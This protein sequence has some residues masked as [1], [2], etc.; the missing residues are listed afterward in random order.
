M[1][2]ESG[3]PRRIKVALQEICRQYRRGSGLREPIKTNIETIIS[4]LLIRV[5]QDMKVV[6][7]CLNAIAQFGRKDY[8]LNGVLQSIETHRDNPEIAGSAV[9]ALFKIDSKTLKDANRITVLPREIIALGALQNTHPSRLDLTGVRIN[10]ERAAPD[11]LKLAL[12]TVGIDK[13]VENLFD[14]KFTNQQIV[15]A[16][17]KHDDAIVK[18]YSVWAIL[19]N[20]LL[21]AADLG[22][23]LT[24]LDREP[25]NVRAKVYSLLAAEN[26]DVKRRHEFILQGSDDLE[27]EARSGLASTL[28]DVWYDSLD[29]VTVPWYED[30]TD[31]IVREGLLDHFAKFAGDSPS[32]EEIAVEAFKTNPAVRDRLYGMAAGKPLYGRFKR[33]DLAGETPNLFKEDGFQQEGS[34]RKTPAM[35]ILM[36]GASPADEEVLRV[37]AENR[38]IKRQIESIGERPLQ[39]DTEFAVRVSDL[40]RHMLKAK[41]TILH[42]S[43]HGDT[44][45]WLVFEDDGGNAYPVEPDALADLMKI[46]KSELQCVVLNCCYSNALAEAIAK[47]IPIVIGCDGSV[48]DSAATS[49]SVGFYRGLASGKDFSQSFELGVNEI[50]LTSDRSLSEMYRIHKR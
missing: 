16:L 8:S 11:V 34:H 30:E 20:S 37:N 26:G 36:L 12:I 4:G 6:R 23:D 7:W 41:P 46:F 43:G 49:F 19:E 48:V 33:I 28:K 27:A 44:G 40:Q 32:Y 38:E 24:N 1:E 18:Q 15:Q 35:K 14:P 21:S 22:V 45:S 10:I 42:F 29:T 31:P 25:V 2:L 3:E 9:A 39:I 17:G 47:H 50:N 13:A 5:S